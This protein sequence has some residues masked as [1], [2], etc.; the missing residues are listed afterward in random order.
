MFVGIAR[1]LQLQSAERGLRTTG[2]PGTWTLGTLRTGSNASAKFFFRLFFGG[3]KATQGHALGFPFRPSLIRIVP[4]SSGVCVC[5]FH[6]RQISRQTT[7]L[8]SDPVQQCGGG[9]CRL[10]LGFGASI[11]AGGRPGLRPG[12]AAGVAGVQGAGAAGT[13]R[14]GSFQGIE[15]QT[16][17]GEH[18]QTSRTSFS[19][20]KR[21]E[22]FILISHFVIL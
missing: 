18:H 1:W 21:Q 8:R 20:R 2:V 4:L 19:D 10:L 9:A 12:L 22:G 6:L 3:R 15:Q 11:L 13:V 7:D 14:L 5:V 16:R 17:N